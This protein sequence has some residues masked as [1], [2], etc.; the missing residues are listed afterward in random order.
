MAGCPKCGQENEAG[1]LL[2]GSCGFS[3]T[4][5]G[6]DGDH[7][8]VVQ[9]A[10]VDESPTIQANTIDDSEMG[11]T[12]IIDEV[13]SADDSESEI[14][15]DLNTNSDDDHPQNN[16]SG[17][18]EFAHGSMGES[19]P[20]LHEGSADLEEEL[21]D[22]DISQSHGSIDDSEEMSVADDSS[23]NDSSNADELSESGSMDQS[24]SDASMSASGQSESSDSYDDP[25]GQSSAL[26]DGEIEP[27]SDSIDVEAFE[28]EQRDRALLLPDEAEQPSS[29]SVE[30]APNTDTTDGFTEMLEASDDRIQS[31]DALPLPD[32][33]GVKSPLS[34]GDGDL[35]GESERWW[36]KPTELAEPQP[37]QEPAP[38][39][40]QLPDNNH[41]NAP[42]AAVQVTTIP[43][44]AVETAR[45]RN[46]AEE[47]DYSVPS[48]GPPMP[49][50]IGIAVAVLAAAA[51][52][53]L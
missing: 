36:L 31:M 8:T 13:A 53:L 6:V 30:A 15:A 19:D 40:E 45:Q 9:S 26:N 27:D 12:V 34:M 11:E 47:D 35:A 33:R 24:E 37:I 52:F 28:A 22:V 5:D 10:V 3:L 2:C 14:E 29:G 49:L 32:T 38:T 46:F 44:P 1:L 21:A 7:P 17:A 25:S 18:E 39:E 42:Q 43:A 20:D 23:N 51:F 4:Q 16:D 48:S 41:D 50:I